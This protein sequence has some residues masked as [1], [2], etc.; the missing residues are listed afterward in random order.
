MSRAESS[1]VAPLAPA[2]I[3]KVVVDAM[4]DGQITFCGAYD[5]LVAV[6][7]SF[8]W[9][10]SKGDSVATFMLLGVLDATTC[11]DV[12]PKHVELAVARTTDAA[13]PALR[14]ARLFL[15]SERTVSDQAAQLQARGRDTE[16]WYSRFFDG[17]ARDAQALIHDAVVDLFTWADTAH[18]M[19]SENDAFVRHELR[20]RGSAALREGLLEAAHRRLDHRLNDALTA[21]RW[22]RRAA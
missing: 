1:P 21:S 19:H 9:Y 8:T 5:A 14:V 12:Q 3:A 11:A 10:T 15:E 16:D 17:A 4:R 22:P 20:E 13:A 18:G 2:R 7:Q 6:A